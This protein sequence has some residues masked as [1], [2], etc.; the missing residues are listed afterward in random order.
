MSDAEILL[1]DG[2]LRNKRASNVQNSSGLHVFGWCW[3]IDF[4]KLPFLFPHFL[5][6]AV[7]STLFY[8][9]KLQKMFSKSFF[10]NKNPIGTQRKKEK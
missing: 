7:R 6:T 4:S 1:K 3:L 9:D 8:E 2:I 10:R 5:E